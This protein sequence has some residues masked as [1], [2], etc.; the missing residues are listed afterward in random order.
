MK[1]CFVDNTNFQYNSL[2]IYSSYLR[3]A[4]SVIINL[5]KKLSYLGHN[6]TIINNCPNNAIIDNIRWV[7]IHSNFNIEHFDCVV[8]NGDCNLF[9]FAKSKNNI[10]FSHSIQ[11]LEKFIRKKQM[12]SYLKYKPRVCFL[13][14]YHK[15]NRPKL[16]YFFGSFDLQWSVDDIF[17]Q[18]KISN[19]I[20]SNQAIFTSNKDRN[21]EYLSKIWIEHIFPKNKNLRLLSNINQDNLKNYGI[22]KRNIGNKKNLI[23]DLLDSKIYLIPGHKA[24]L[25]CLAAEEARELCIPIVT[26]GIGCL[27]ERV[28]HEKTGFIAKNINEF[29]EYTL[30]LFS[31]DKLWLKLRNNLIN[32]RGKK[33][34]NNVAKEFINLI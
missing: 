30:Q 14:R 13:S 5:S 24:E 4:E 22:F 16:L 20:N 2:D 3:G 1:I 21:S 23:K 12:I 8:S 26:L 9:K 15:K 19:N 31:N 25:F 34:W 32:I 7:N 33:N 6:V 11:T 18:T 17:I 28:E 10:L 27:N 29:A